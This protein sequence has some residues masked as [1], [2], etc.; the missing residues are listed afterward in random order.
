MG[1]P[2]SQAFG[3]GFVQGGQ[4]PIVVDYLPLTQMLIG[5][6]IIDGTA[7]YSIEASADN[8]MDRDGK[9]NPNARWFPEACSAEVLFLSAKEGRGR[10]SDRYTDTT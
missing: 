7:Q 4:T 8:I 9:L 5:C 6:F 3:P 2:I 10:P 1:M